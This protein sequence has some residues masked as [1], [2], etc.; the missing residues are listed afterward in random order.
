MTT[1]ATRTPVR[2]TAR[3]QEVAMGTRMGMAL[4]MTLLLAGCVLP[5]DVNVDGDGSHPDVIHGSGRPAT[6]S[7]QVAG[8]DRVAADGVGR[9]IIERTGRETL[10]LTADD[11]LLDYFVA[12]VR[13]GT[14]Y[15]GPRPGV[16]LTPETEPVYRIEAATMDRIDGSGV[17]SFDAFIGRQPTFSV[18]LSGVCSLTARGSVNHLSVDLSGVSAFRGFDLV[19]RL[20]GVFASGASSAEV[21]ATERL[22]AQ[23][24]GTSIIRY[25]GDPPAVVARTSGLASIEPD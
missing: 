20:A 23:A 7:L 11:N 19:G 17:V 6:V 24:S 8:F 14:L 15:L 1:R 2:R 12:E 5:V 4:G 18:G 3:T 21:H 25:R 13:R 16:S 10:T 9:V 22:E